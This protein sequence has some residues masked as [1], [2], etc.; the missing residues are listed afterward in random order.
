MYPLCMQPVF[1]PAHHI[2]FSLISPQNLIQASTFCAAQ[3]STKPSLTHTCGL[4]CLSWV[5]NHTK[6]LRSSLEIASK[7]VWLV[8]EKT[9]DTGFQM[10]HELQPP[11]CP[12]YDP[13]IN[14]DC[15]RQ[16]HV[17]CS[18]YLKLMRLAVTELKLMNH[19]SSLSHSVWAISHVSY[20]EN[21]LPLHDTKGCSL[22]F[23]MKFDM[24]G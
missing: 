24:T 13:C 16:C 23:W 19:F 1:I 12:L 18:R 22:P 8:Q 7:N 6:H 3:Q 5:Y 14:F 10:E 9:G 17:I 21:D 2:H 20:P 15:H 4:C 11:G